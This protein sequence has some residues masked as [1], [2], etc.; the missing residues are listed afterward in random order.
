MWTWRSALFAAWSW[1]NAGAQ[2]ACA[3]DSREAEIR[4]LG[5]GG[6]TLFVVKCWKEN[7]LVSPRRIAGFLA[8]AADRSLPVPRPAG[9][10]V[11]EDGNPVL[12]M[13]ISSVSLRRSA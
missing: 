4:Y 13:M 5:E 10:G 7:A 9:W 1:Q 12:A 6:M 3:S 2:P 11:D 8:R